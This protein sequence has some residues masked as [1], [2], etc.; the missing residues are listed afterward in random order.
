MLGRMKDTWSSHT[1]GSSFKYVPL[2]VASSVH[3]CCT[4]M[5]LIL[6]LRLLQSKYK[7]E[8]ISGK[9]FFFFPSLDHMVRRQKK[10]TKNILPWNGHGA[11]VQQ[12]YAK[13]ETLWP[14]HI[15]RWPNRGKC[16]IVM[17]KKVMPSVSALWKNSHHS[18]VRCK[19]E[20]KPVLNEGWRDLFFFYKSGSTGWPCASTRFTFI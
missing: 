11:A 5:W 8:C 12:S 1:W 17:C 13:Q 7:N 19:S 9:V 6:T 14:K 10:R 2:W 20:T 4:Q 18:S 15:K 3:H 16:R